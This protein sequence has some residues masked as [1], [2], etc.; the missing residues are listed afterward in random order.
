MEV[1]DNICEHLDKREYVIGIY[2]DLQKAF[3]AV[4]YDIHLY[5]LSNY[6]IRVVVH[7]WFK[8]YLTGR[9]QFTA[10]GL[11]GFCSETALVSTGFCPGTFVISIIY[12]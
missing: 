12:K 2:L 9:K 5:K 1:L 4:N 6:G 3:N 10:L 7:Q 11:G 8:S